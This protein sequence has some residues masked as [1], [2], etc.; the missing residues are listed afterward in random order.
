MV[1][2]K[3]VL[4]SFNVPREASSR[5]GHVVHGPA[6]KQLQATIADVTARVPGAP[7]TLSHRPHTSRGEV[8]RGAIER[9][10]GIRPL[11]HGR[12]PGYGTCDGH[13]CVQV[14]VTTCNAVA[15]NTWCTATGVCTQTCTSRGSCELVTHGTLEETL[16][17]FPTY[18]G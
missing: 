18:R 7:C 2:W 6:Y 5:V 11:C 1:R 4:R 13:I 17:T 3:S 10:P 16:A 12:P 15:S 8:F 14:A 9:I